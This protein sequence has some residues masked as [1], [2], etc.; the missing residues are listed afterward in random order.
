MCFTLVDPSTNLS[1]QYEKLFIQTQK[2]LYD[3]T[4]VIYRSSDVYRFKDQLQMA[5]IAWRQLNRD[6]MPLVTQLHA[7]LQSSYYPTNYFNNFGSAKAGMLHLPAVIKF[8]GNGFTGEMNLHKKLNTGG[9]RLYAV[10]VILDRSKSVGEVE[11]ARQV[12]VF[13]SLALALHKMKILVCLLSYDDQ[14]TLLKASLCHCQRPRHVEHYAW[15]SR[16][17]LTQWTIYGC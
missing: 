9:E 3:K 5:S 8:M 16:T 4:L 7:V 1:G 17:A 13:M 6:L 12:E 11:Y 14:V 2:A 10:T 15:H